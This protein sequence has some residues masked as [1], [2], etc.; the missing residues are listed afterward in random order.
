MRFSGGKSSKVNA[1]LDLAFL[2]MVSASDIAVRCGGASCGKT[3]MV[4]GGGLIDGAPVV[5][6]WPDGDD[7]RAKHVELMYGAPVAGV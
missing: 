7:G 4:V 6:E 5:G 3:D 2:V 1:R